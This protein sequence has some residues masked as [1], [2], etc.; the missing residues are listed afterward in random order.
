[1]KL[2]NNLLVPVHAYAV[3]RYGTERKCEHEHESHFTFSAEKQIMTMWWT[4]ASFVMLFPRNETIVCWSFISACTP[5]V[6]TILIH[7]GTQQSS[8]D[9]HSHHSGKSLNF[10]FVINGLE[11]FCSR[12]SHR[13]GV[14]DF[15]CTLFNFRQDFA[16]KFNNFCNQIRYW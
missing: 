7:T 3:V 5:I 13:H 12:F 16:T 15:Q 10:Q 9:K 1:M 2:N 8:P 11:Q 6:Q 14:D 4:E